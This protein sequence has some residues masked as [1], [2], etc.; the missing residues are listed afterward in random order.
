MKNLLPLSLALAALSTPL[1]ANAQDAAPAAPA[2]ETTTAPTATDDNAGKTGEQIAAYNAG[3]A[4]LNKNDLGEAA[5]QFQK[6]I[7]LAPN[8]AGALMFLGYVRL[9]QQQYSDALTALEAAQAQS[10]RLGANLLSILYN[11]LGIAYANSNRGADALAAYQK[12]IDASKTEYTDA[13]YNLAFAQLAQKNYKDALPNLLKLRDARKDDTAFQSSIY[14]GLAEAYENTGDWGQALAAYKQ[15]TVL[16]PNDPAA[17]FNFALALSKT[18]RIDDAIDQ[19]SQVL[20]QNPN[21]EPTLLL[22][23]DLYSRKG[24]WKD[25]KDVLNRYVLADD[26]NFTAWFTLGVAYDYSSDFSSALDAYAKAEA[27]SPNDPAVKNNIGRILFKQGDHFPE[28]YNEAAA[29]LKEALKLDPSFDDALVNLALVYTAQKKWDDAIEQW[30]TYLK[31]IRLALQKPGLTAADKADWKRKAQ[32]ARGALAENYL[33]AGDYPNAVKEYKQLLGDTPDNLDA[34]SNLGLAQYH[35]K[36]YEAA[37]ATYRDLIKRDPKNA[38]AYNNL[39]VVL[40]ANG[41]RE[42]AVQ[43]YRKAL[44]LKPDYPEARTNVERLTTAT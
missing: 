44:S 8:D 19:G 14:D 28:K 21:H 4:A 6:A 15:V 36:D 3:L 31:D 12:A 9:R 43:S 10:A 16:N 1:V 26:K 33:K 35:T 39:G 38:I 7:E 5:A 23:G 24:R 17:R 25:A 30:N 40:E 22:L 37:I 2:A 41:Q 32:S 13:R 11:N 20:K 34:M 18:G 27:L 29:R 42:E